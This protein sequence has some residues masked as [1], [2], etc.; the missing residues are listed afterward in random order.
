MLRWAQRRLMPADYGMFPKA[1]VLMLFCV[2]SISF[3]GFAS[4]KTYISEAE[5]ETLSFPEADSFSDQI[6][7]PDEKQRDEISRRLGKIST[8]EIFSCRAA[9]REGKLLGYTV[10]DT[11]KSKSEKIKYALA[12][13]PNLEVLSV[14]ILSYDSSR[15]AKISQP[16]FLQQFTGRTPATFEEGRIR[17]VSGATLSSKAMAQGIREILVY[18]S[19]LFPGEQLAGIDGGS[20]HET[21]LPAEAGQEEESHGNQIFYQRSRYVMGAPLEISFFSRSK[22]TAAG[23]FEEAFREADRLDR[24]LSVYHEDSEISRINRLARQ[25]V[26]VSGEVLELIKAAV[27]YGAKTAGGFDVTV[28]PLIN[29]WN[30]AAVQNTP[31]T[32]EGISDTLALTGPGIMGIDADAGQVWLEKKGAFI[33]LGGIGKGYAI[34]RVSAILERRGIDSALVNFGGNIRALGSPPG[35]SGWIVAIPDPEDPESSIDEI[36]ISNGA[37]STSADYE[38][39]FKIGGEPF[40]H[41]IDPVTGRPVTGRLNITV[42]AD[43]ATAADALSTGLYPLS[44]QRARSISLESGTSVMI[45][46]ENGE[47]FRSDSYR[48]YSRD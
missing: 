32:A 30:A 9:R 8:K 27:F 19:V 34:D 29:L 46:S 35:E 3:P 17:H 5:A 48:E 47:S 7:V 31:P 41:I 45:L 42:I 28:G 10:V 44:M 1:F 6:L 18:L 37:V 20:I 24:L 33:N 12:A 15:G 26:S 43:S 14:E 38:R 4:A 40:S 22:L 36:V 39:G 13:S 2:F 21:G 25:K 23:A 16:R 11:V